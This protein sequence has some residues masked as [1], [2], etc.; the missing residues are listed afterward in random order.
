MLHMECRMFFSAS[1][2]SYVAMTKTQNLYVR[3]QLCLLWY[4]WIDI[5]KQQ[6]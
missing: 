3:F 6:N 4:V 5:D 1:V 2:S